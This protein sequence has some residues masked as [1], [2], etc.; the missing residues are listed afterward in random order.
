MTV[1]ELLGEFWEALHYAEDDGTSLGEEE[2]RKQII[3]EF[4]NKIRE[5]VL[6]G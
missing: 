5:A 4:A 2:V 6:K 3:D 1:E